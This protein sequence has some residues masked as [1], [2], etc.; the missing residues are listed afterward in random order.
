MYSELYPIFTRVRIAP[1]E[2]LETFLR[3]WRYHHP[4]EPAQLRYAGRSAT[5]KSVAH[6]H[7]GDVLYE[8]AEAPGIWHEQV[9]GPV[10]ILAPAARATRWPNGGEPH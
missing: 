2:C 1:L 7:G 6:Y 4:L 10:K 8:L 9:L 3:T 5:V